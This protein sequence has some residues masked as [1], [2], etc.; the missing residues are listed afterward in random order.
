MT[1]SASLGGPGDEGAEERAWS[2]A[3]LSR[4]KLGAPVAAA[5]KAESM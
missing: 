1:R 5:W 4:L 3:K 2:M